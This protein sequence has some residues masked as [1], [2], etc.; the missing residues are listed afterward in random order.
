[1]SQY[2]VFCGYKHRQNGGWNDH[3]A[4]LSTIE[5]CKAF[6][7]KTNYSTRCERYTVSSGHG[8]YRNEDRLEFDFDWYQIVDAA[9]LKLVVEDHRSI[10]TGAFKQLPDELLQAVGA[11]HR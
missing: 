2:L 8:R 11:E 1:M 3:K 6:L 4:A 5:D 10:E 7:A 9:N